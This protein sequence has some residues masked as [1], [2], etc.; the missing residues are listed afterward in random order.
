[1]IHLVIGEDVYKRRQNIADIARGVAVPAEKFDGTELT[2][3][4]LADCMAGA[5]LFSS[6]RLIII[7]DL[8]DNKPLWDKFAD[9]MHRVGSDT[10]IVLVETKPDK[11]TKAYKTIAKVASLHTA[12]P[13]TERQVGEA[14]RWL[15]ARAKALGLS[16][17]Q[18]QAANL[19]SRATLPSERPGAFT[20]NQQI[21]ENALQTLAVLDTVSDD[22]IATVLPE[23]TTDNVFELMDVALAGNQARAKSLLSNLHVS[24]DPYMT[25]GY[26]MSQWAQLVAL[27]LARE[28]ADAV[29]AAI[30]SSPYVLKKLSRH[31]EGLSLTTIQQLT[32]RLAQLDVQTKTTGIDPWVAVDSFVAELM[33]QKTA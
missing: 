2:E 28:P 23:S 27:K 20:V 32:E 16:F 6:E 12:D 14:T 15:L 24:A 18:P 13:W 29:A 5:T 7:T 8:S 9:W 10:T 33:T 22:A 4:Q 31:A 1:M 25:L 21:L 30:G 11:R 17:T 3:N 26:L 19:V